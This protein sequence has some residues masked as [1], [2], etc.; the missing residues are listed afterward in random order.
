[1]FFL[2]FLPQNQQVCLLVLGK[3]YAGEGET[4]PKFRGKTTPKR[5]KDLWA[6]AQ[7]FLF[8]ISSI[9]SPKRSPLWTLLLFFC[10]NIVINKFT[11]ISLPPSPLRRLS[12]A[13]I[14]FLQFISSLPPS[15][16]RRFGEVRKLFLVPCS[17]QG[18]HNLIAIYYLFTSHLPQGESAR[19]GS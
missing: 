14:K 19:L 17:F 9:V 4:L 10:K 11:S 5:P 2:C 18:L 1:M 12:V 13:R 8:Q 15:P 3:S 7:P 16:L 6:Q